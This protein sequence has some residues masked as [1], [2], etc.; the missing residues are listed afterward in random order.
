[1]DASREHAQFMP[2]NHPDVRSGVT[3]RVEGLRAGAGRTVQFTKRRP[4]TPQ[5]SAVLLLLV[6]AFAAPAFAQD[7]SAPVVTICSSSDSSRSCGA[8]VR[9][10]NALNKQRHSQW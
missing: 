1:M 7:K 9:V 10:C 3:I 8:H 2:Q 6:P 5:I 4:L